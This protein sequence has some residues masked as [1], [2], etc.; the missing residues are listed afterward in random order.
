MYAKSTFI[1][2]IV[3]NA[4]ILCVIINFFIGSE[5][6]II[7]PS[8]SQK[9]FHEQTA[10]FT[11]LSIHTFEENDEPHYS[12]DYTTKEVYNFISVFGIVFNGCTGILAGANLSGE[13]KNPAKSIPKGTLLAEAYTFTIYA[14]LYILVA[15][16]CS[17]DLLQMNYTFLQ[18]INFYPPL[19][20]VGTIL[21]TTS[22][23]L[24]AFLG[25]S[26][27][28]FA[29][30]KDKILGV[31]LAPFAK[32]ATS[33]GNPYLCVAFTAFLIQLVLFVNNVNDIAPMVSIFFLMVYFFINVACALLDIA[34][35]PNFR[36]SF[37]YF[38][39][40]VSVVGMIG[41]LTMIFIISPL[42]AFVNLLILVVL[43]IVI[44][45]VG[46]PTVW[47]S[48]T[49]GLTFYLVRKFLLKLDS[50]KDHVKFWRPQILLLVNNPK[51]CMPLLKFTN[52]L[53][54]SGLYV[55]GKLYFSP[56]SPVNT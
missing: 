33:T 45:I 46:P 42:Y 38:S 31:L 8:E 54:K 14:L 25:A 37:K 20:F 5:K 15:F 13:L 47:G 50:R 39:W 29:V 4:I 32:Y 48:I 56:Q 17:T 51:S 40:H 53:K 10:N 2:F 3:V 6:P 26:R 18:P 21:V 43:I 11:G 16:T 1:I 28:L 9:L 41:C 55:I 19:V 24:S 49:Q 36:P 44:S 34:S 7:L 35:A 23:A 52:D 22:A 27:I 30:S 12:E